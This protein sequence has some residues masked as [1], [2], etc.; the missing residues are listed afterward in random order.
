MGCN[1]K[2]ASFLFEW[3]NEYILKY[4]EFE[5]LKDTYGKYYDVRPIL[6]RPYSPVSARRHSKY[7]SVATASEESAIPFEFRLKAASGSQWLLS[8]ESGSQ[9]RRHR[10]GPL[11]AHKRNAYVIPSRRLSLPLPT[12]FRHTLSLCRR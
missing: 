12:H 6:N 11:C 2:A 5:Q 4:N 3:E 10:R 7:C 1:S 9:H 8:L